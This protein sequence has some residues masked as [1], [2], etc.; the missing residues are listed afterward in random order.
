MQV[1]QVEITPDPYEPSLLAQA[2]GVGE[3]V[4]VSG[5]A[6]IGRD[7]Q[8]LRVDDFDEQPGQALRTQT[9][10]CAPEDPASRTS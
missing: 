8:I 6:G 7:G 10:F 3:L 1:Q 4:F 2:R 9:E 5:Q